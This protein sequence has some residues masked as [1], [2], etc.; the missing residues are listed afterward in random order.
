MTHLG[1]DTISSWIRGQL[2]LGL[3][4]R[5]NDS[6][7]CCS[8]FA[9]DDTQFGLFGQPLRPEGPIPISSGRFPEHPLTIN[10]ISANVKPISTNLSIYINAFFPE[11]APDSMPYRSPEIQ[12]EV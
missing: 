11:N 4:F 5:R 3:P 7:A 10:R 8:S 6:I 2:T 12:N 1:I 9:S